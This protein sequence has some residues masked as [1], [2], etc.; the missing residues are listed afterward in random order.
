MMMPNSPEV[1]WVQHRIEQD[2]RRPVNPDERERPTRRRERRPDPIGVQMMRMPAEE[3]VDDVDQRV[4]RGR[5]KLR[6]ALAA[7]LRRIPAG[8][9][10]TA[11]GER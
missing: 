5:G 3:L 2:R 1:M 9:F 10:S 7:I 6:E 8:P 4:D 11:T